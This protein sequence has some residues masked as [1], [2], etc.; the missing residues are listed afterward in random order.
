MVA[1]LTAFISLVSLVLL[2]QACQ[3][4]TALPQLSSPTSKHVTVSPD[5]THPVQSPLPELPTKDT[6]PSDPTLGITP[7]QIPRFFLEEWDENTG[8]W[9]DFLTIGD[10]NLY[11]IYNEAGVLVLS[12]TGKDISSYF[13]YESGEYDRVNIS[14]RM[15]N[16]S[17]GKISTILVCNYSETQGWYEFDM[18]SDGFWQIRAHDTRGRTGY[19]DLQSG[20][21]EA[22][23]LGTAVNEYTVTCIGNKLGLSINGTKIFEFT[24]NFMK[25]SSGK[26]GLGLISYSQVP[27]LVESAWIRI[28]EP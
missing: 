5:P 1:R 17:E 4:S 28:S 8:N 9:E 22:I 20:G 23:S 18:G 12:L 11:D 26:I 13:I 16:R 19:V 14:T 10:R 6:V 15:E 2:V 21:T 3:P 27:V 25:Y 7:T 24:D